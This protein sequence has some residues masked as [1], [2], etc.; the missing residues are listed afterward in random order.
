MSTSKL[1][2]GVR[3]ATRVSVPTVA[4]SPKKDYCI[5]GDDFVGGVPNAPNST[6][7]PVS[8]CTDPMK[9]LGWSVGWGDEYDQTDSGQPISLKGVADGTYI[10]HALA[11]PDH[12]IS[13]SNSTNQVTDTL[14][15]IGGNGSTV[16]VLSQTNPVADDVHDQLAPPPPPPLG[17]Q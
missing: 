13:E 7:I 17:G 15:Q 3:T 12:V 8:N 11:D 14:L 10:L 1:P 5:T 9:P 4:T 6:F 2:C 16:T